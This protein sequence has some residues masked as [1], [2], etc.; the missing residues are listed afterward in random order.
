[1]EG[2]VWNCLADLAFAVFWLRV[3][4]AKLSAQG[5]HLV[6]ACTT[7]FFFHLLDFENRV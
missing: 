7:V 2:I 5:T 3:L 1:M 6:V 4:P